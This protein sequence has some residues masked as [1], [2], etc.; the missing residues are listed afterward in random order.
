MDFSSYLQGLGLGASL[1]VAIGAQNA[2][3]LTQ[4]IRRNHPWAVAGLCAIID[5]LL[6]AV[7]VAGIGTLVARS[8]FLHVAASL[9]GGTFL[10]CFGG[11]ALKSAFSGQALEQARNGPSSLRQTLA[12]VLAVSLL[13]P[14][15]YLDTVVML[16]ALSGR[17]GDA[18]RW[19]FGAGAGTASL[20][21]FF[22]LAQCGRALAPLFKKPASWR[23]LNLLVC[24]VVWWIAFALLLDLY[25]EFAA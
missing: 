24:L 9:G 19:L 3:V 1:I 10:L 13:N 21:W 4:G 2:F 22:G 16:G 15:V 11:K 12:A 14:H 18:G 20:L 7:G 25:R 17:H 23:V 8:A 6:I 5:L